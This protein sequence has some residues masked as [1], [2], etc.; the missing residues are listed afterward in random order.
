[1]ARRGE[2]I[3][4]GSAAE[5]TPPS[6]V[7][8]AA[9]YQ[10]PDEIITRNAAGDDVAEVEEPP[11]GTKLDASIDIFQVIC[12]KEAKEPEWH[13]SEDVIPTLGEGEAVRLYLVSITQTTIEKYKRFNDPGLSKLIRNHR[14]N[15]IAPMLESSDYFF[16]TWPR[17]ANQ[18]TQQWK[19]DARIAAH[20]PWNLPIVI[21]PHDLCL[22][23]ESYNELGR[24]GRPHAP[25][26]T[27]PGPD[28]F[29]S[30]R[31]MKRINE[32]KENGEFRSLVSGESVSYYFMQGEDGFVGKISVRLWPQRFVCTDTVIM[33]ASSS[34]TSLL[35]LRSQ[36]KSTSQANTYRTKMKRE[37]TIVSRTLRTAA[38]DFLVA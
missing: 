38:L 37:L 19:I 23:H 16:A 10:V 4:K 35:E 2:D 24:L 11:D 15:E 26:E 27:K 1:M 21:D 5:E 18:N 12:W 9:P 3:E 34:L 22:N 29:R 28:P 20:R 8:G 17:L 25:L 30:E 7:A 31:G 14:V 32:K 6:N 13:K 36:K 33:Q